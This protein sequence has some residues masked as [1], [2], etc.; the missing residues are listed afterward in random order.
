MLRRLTVNADDFGLSSGINRGIIEAHERGI[1]TSAS[2]MVRGAAAA[3]AAEYGRKNLRLS[4]GLHIDLA[5]WTY[6][7]GA[8]TPL[9]QVV[10]VADA[11]AVESEVRRQLAAFIGLMDGPPTHLDSHQHVHRDEPLRSAAQRLAAELNIPLRHV[12]PSVRYCGEFYGQTDKGGPMP[13][14]IT[15][16]ALVGVLRHL[17]P[18]TTELGCHPGYADE[19][20]TSYRSERAREV[21]VLCDPRVRQLLAEEHIELV[22][23]HHVSLSG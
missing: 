23:F 14:L 12:T 2:L 9:Y 7:G 19:V 16:E 21:A 4:V 8:W 15:V 6:R 11:A 1:V 3:A 18:G 13:D 22:S 20:E 10:D 5:E 17:R